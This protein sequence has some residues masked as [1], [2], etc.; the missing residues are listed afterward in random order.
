MRIKQGHRMPRPPASSAKTDTNRPFARLKWVL[1]AALLA[2][3]GSGGALLGSGGMAAVAEVFKDPLSLFADRSPGSRPEGAL[4][5]TKR[6]K[7]KTEPVEMVLSEDR[8]RPPLAPEDA[9]PESAPAPALYP[10][11]PEP[12]DL[13]LPEEPLLALPGDPIFGGGT[14]G[15]L[16][17]IGDL[18]FGSPGSPGGGGGC[19]SPGTPTTPTDPLIPAVPEPATWAMLILGFF[20]VGGS[21]RASAKRRAG[22]RAA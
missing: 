14:P 2:T 16:I 6:A 18:P 8:T 11:A 12:L 7:A 19:C 3:L 9:T 10:L 20:M 5:A 4:L 13:L 22:L 17:P 15:G 21:L 1:G